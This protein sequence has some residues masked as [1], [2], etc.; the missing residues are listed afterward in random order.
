MFLRNIILFFCTF[1]KSSAPHIPDAF[2]NSNNSCIYMGF[3]ATKKGDSV[4][5]FGRF[6]SKKFF[7]AN[8]SVKNLYRCEYYISIFYIIIC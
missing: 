4:H 1:V 3:Q 5:F 2:D 6:G 7:S 8:F